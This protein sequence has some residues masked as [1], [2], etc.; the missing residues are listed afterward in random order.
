MKI[1]QLN[2]G[3]FDN[4]YS[5]LI[6]DENNVG[7]LIDPTGNKEIIEKTIKKYGVLIALQLITHRHPDHVELVPHFK[8]KGVP[9]LQ[10]EDF[11]KE[12]GFLVGSILVKVIFTPGHTSDSVCFL[13]E[14]NLFTVDTL[15]VK[16]IGTTD[17]GG[18]K[19]EQEKSLKKL[20]ILNKKII[21]WP[22]HN[23]N[24][25]KTT[26]REALSFVHKKPSKKT[27]DKIKKNI[28]KYEKNLK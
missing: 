26:L 6:F 21:V 3:G 11:I 15:F 24:G 28:E 22:G 13:I 1:V 27:L 17:Y 4:N 23:Y 10:F 18:N 7:L 9:F 19:K 5:Y 12:P 2:V 8:E 25:E 16:G 14:N 20:E